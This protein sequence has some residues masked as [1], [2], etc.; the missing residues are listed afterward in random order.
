VRAPIHLRRKGKV[1]FLELDTPGSHINI[2]TPEAGAELIELLEAIDP[3]KTRI[4][5]IRS[6][7]HHSFINGVGLLYAASMRRETIAKNVAREVRRTFTAVGACRALT[8]AAVE[9]SCYGCG[10]ELTLWCDHRVASDSFD[11]EFYL[12]EMEDYLFTPVFG[13]L[14]RLAPLVGYEE[15]I[16]LALWGKR[17]RAREA[18]AIGLVDRVLH[19]D[20]FDRELDEVLA[21]LSTTKRSPPPAPARSIDSG[22][23]ARATARIRALPR[24]L[25]PTYRTALALIERSIDRKRGGEQME[26]AELDAFARTLTK[27]ASAKAM[28]FFFV[29][30][31]SGLVGTGGKMRSLPD[32][33][34]IA[35]GRG[36]AAARLRRI[37]EARPLTGVRIGDP[38]GADLVFGSGGDVEVQIAGAHR[39]GRIPATLPALFFPFEPEEERLCEIALPPNASL[40]PAGLAELLRLLGFVAIVTHPRGVFVIERFV[41][42]FKAELRANPGAERALRAL[43][44]A[45]LSRL[46]A[47]RPRRVR[48]RARRARKGARFGSLDATTSVL[49]RLIAEALR[50]LAE[51]SLQHR[52]QADLLARELFGFPLHLGSLFQ[53]LDERGGDALSD[54]I[55][56]ILGPKEA[57][58]CRLL[59]VHG[60]VGERS[61]AR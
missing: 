3:A 43:G 19:H 36:A 4:V 6:R 34:V 29:R 15:A 44:F 50:C 53:Q 28:S 14:Q 42:A 18:K 45:P 25:R 16:E 22:V 24:E 56:E 35:F 30:E 38:A 51:G 10:L 47:E 9:G 46:L 57:E 21:R 55:L 39:R 5:V 61:E 48:N 60:F 7:K 59:A 23:K 52:A 32:R 2:L 20:R 49:A 41:S 31:T 27:P 37:A 11:T 8:V 12:T 54:S 58:A 33:F 13:A 1:A 40:P 17:I 26:E